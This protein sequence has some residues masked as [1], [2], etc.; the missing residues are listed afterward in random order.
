MKKFDAVVIGSGVAGLSAAFGLKKSGKTVAIVENDLWGGT[1]PNRG[2]D[3]KKVLIAAVEA[4]DHVD[5][6]K[7]KG[8][9]ASPDIQ[10]SEL[11]AFKRTFTE[12]VPQS[13]QDSLQKSGIE[14]LVGSA[15]FLDAHQL[16]V[17]ETVI[18]SKQFLIATGQ[19]PMILDI[20]GKEFFK[21]STDFLDLDVLPKRIAFVG[22]GYVSIELATI[23]QAAGAEV[24]IIHHND[25]PLK[26]FDK[27]LVGELMEQLKERGVQLDFNVDLQKIT[28]NSDDSYQLQ[29]QGFEKEVDLVICATGRIPNVE[30]LQLENAGVAY[31]KHGI[32]VNEFLQTS[33]PTIFASG[34]V[35]AKR[36]PKLTPV[37]TYE[38]NYVV[39]AMDKIGEAI[40]YPSIPTIVFGSPKLAQVGVTA[41]EAV[42]HPEK[43]TIR[44]KDLTSW[45][46]YHRVNEPV[47][48]AKLIFEN[49]QLVGATTLSGHADELINLLAIAIDKKI[50]AAE[51]KRFIMGYPTTASDLSY[52]L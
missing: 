37:S 19:R 16:Q 22:A 26:A 43:Y 13:R 6:L 3:P 42:E 33:V 44:E 21:T 52:L 32:I 36:I 7:E 35:L 14:T 20:E 38:A 49:K 45:F 9:A 18:Q 30:T 27:D 1:C 46:T 41:K 29:G 34:D 17:G 25:Q 12:P 23:A 31:D 10:W 11:M 47:A 39:K 2:C 8:F 5:Q 4:K 51:I 24:S 50:N 28:K 15:R 40:H 48:K